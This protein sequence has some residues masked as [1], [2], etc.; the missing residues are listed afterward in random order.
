MQAKKLEVLLENSKGLIGLS[1]FFGRPYAISD[2][3]EH[4]RK[5]KFN[6]AKPFKML[7]QV[8]DALAEIKAQNAEGKM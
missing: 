2:V 4:V 3:P 6:N 1:Q 8:D 7:I 5:Y